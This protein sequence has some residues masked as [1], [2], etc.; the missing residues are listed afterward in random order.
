MADSPQVVPAQLV[1]VRAGRNEARRLPAPRLA[2]R[3]LD[4]GAEGLQIVLGQLGFEQRG[5]E[6]LVVVRIELRL[7]PPHHLGGSVQDVS[8]AVRVEQHAD[9]RRRLDPAA[10]EAALHHVL[11]GQHLPGADAKAGAQLGVPVL[12]AGLDADDAPQA[13]LIL[14]HG[15]SPPGRRCRPRRRPRSSAAAGASPSASGSPHTCRP[16]WSRLWRRA[17]RASRLPRR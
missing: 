16:A 5:V 2:Q 8:A 9:L 13:V 1:H 10:V 6:R 14:A 11:G 4:P 7:S 17:P 12:E 15:V 3:H